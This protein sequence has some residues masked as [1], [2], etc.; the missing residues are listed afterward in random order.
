MRLLEADDDGYVLFSGHTKLPVVIGDEF[1]GEFV[2]ANAHVKNLAIGNPVIIE[3]VNWCGKC[4]PCRTYW[5]WDVNRCPRL[6]ELGFTVN[7]AFVEYVA[8]SK[9][10]AWKLNDIAEAKGSVEYAYHEVLW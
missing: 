2:E 5:V 4:T 1:S 6:E 9:Y 10:Y 7:G 3:Q 8:P